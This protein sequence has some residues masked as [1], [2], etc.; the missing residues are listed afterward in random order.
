MKNLTLW[1]RL[2]DA[3]DYE[4]FGDDLDAA[5]GALQEAGSGPVLGRASSG[6]ITERYRGNNYISLYWG[7]ETGEDML[8]PLSDEEYEYIK[9]EVE[10]EIEA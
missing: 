9:D 1:M 8:R 4:S 5:I 2:G 7:D 10:D 6:I 3:G